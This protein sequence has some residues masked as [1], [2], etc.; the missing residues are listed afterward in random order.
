MGA[1]PSGRV[2]AAVVFT[3]MVDSTSVVE[4]LGDSRA[5]ALVSRH[6]QI[7]RAE[8]KRFGGRELDTAGDG[9]FATFNEPASAI[10][11]ACAAAR[12][13]R[14]LGIEIRA[15]VHFGECEK[16]GKK[17]GGI[18]VVVGAR[19][20]ALGGAGDVLVSG[21]VAELARGAGFGMGDRG[22]HGLK[23]VEGDWRVLAVESV[24][25]DPRD[26]PLD[27]VEAAARRHAI[28]PV[29][30]RRRLRRPTLIGVAA[31]SV[32]AVAVIVFISA[33][34]EARAKV[35]GSDS[36]ARIDA[37]GRAFD[38]VVDAGR[39]AFPDAIAAGDGKLWVVN[40]AN[41][42]L[43][44]VDPVTAQTK[45]IGTTS[46]PTGVAFVDERVW[47]TYGFSSDPLRRVDVLDPSDPVLGPAGVSV[48]DGSYPIAA[49]DGVLWIAD[50]LGSSLM[51]YDP[52]TGRSES[53]QLPHGS[54]PVALAVNQGTRFLWV[55]A[56][57]VGEVFK[58][59]AD[60]LHAPLER[61][62]TGRSVPT[63]LTTAPD[64]SVWIVARDTDTVLALSP[65][66]ATRV[67]ETVEGHCDGLSGI[68]AVEDAVWVS[69]STSSNVVRLDPHDGSF[70]SAL[71]VAGEPGPMTVDE[72]G[73]VWVAVRGS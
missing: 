8:L 39:G 17:L 55:A 30:A 58:L 5:K 49:G 34:Q 3:D 54:G 50:P 31:V 26:G 35:P 19:I 10:A 62:G 40:V 23:G 70:V 24:D 16:V 63:S 69:C 73:A 51:R 48:P 22:S 42:T 4:E 47:V 56:G 32:L 59:N 45:T 57:R 71:A 13:V 9:F 72:T 67:E 60:D 21:T 38:S 66:G 65:T 18:T 44:Q 15:G 36:L 28:E 11:F 2:L 7:V 27:P 64:G 20:M 53:V 29:S 6:H 33:K 14:E 43:M 12:A 61:F 46:V 25:G 68:V 41:R 37:T 1:S 52:V